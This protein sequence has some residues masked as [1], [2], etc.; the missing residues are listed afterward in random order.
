MFAVSESCLRKPSLFA[1]LVSSSSQA[2]SRSSIVTH[3]SSA[4]RCINTFSKKKNA[5]ALTPTSQGCISSST[6]HHILDAAAT[7]FMARQPFKVHIISEGSL[8]RDY[9]LQDSSSMINILRFLTVHTFQSLAL[10]AWRGVSK[11]RLKRRRRKNAMSMF[12]I[13]LVVR[14]TI[15]ENLSM[16]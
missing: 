5:S 10:R 1:V 6:V 7:Y 9:Q 16:W 2:S 14:T 15:P 8:R 13:R 3:L 4:R 11:C 12:S